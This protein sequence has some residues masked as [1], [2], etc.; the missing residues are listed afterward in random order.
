MLR[1]T[2]LAY[3]RARKYSICRLCPA[4]C[5]KACTASGPIAHADVNSASAPS[6]GRDSDTDIAD[7]QIDT[8]A[9][10]ETAGAAE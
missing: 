5:R 3:V 4:F 2:T 6:N 7:I 1:S 9:D 8:R 10:K